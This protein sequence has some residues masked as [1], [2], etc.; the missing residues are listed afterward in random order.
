MTLLHV[1]TRLLESLDWDEDALE[2]AL[3]RTS[4][5]ATTL[6]DSEGV[7]SVHQLKKLLR[8]EYTEEVCDGLILFYEYAAKMEEELKK[9]EE[10]YND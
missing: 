5:I 10:E 6:Q 1:H 4:E 7:V 2:E 9:D 3:R 8:D